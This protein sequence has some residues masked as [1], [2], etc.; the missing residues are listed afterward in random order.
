MSLHDPRRRPEDDEP[1]PPPQ[2]DFY[3]PAM[4]PLGL[5]HALEHWWWAYRRRRRFLRHI[6]PLLAQDDAQLAS[7]GHRR[8]DLQWALRLPLKVDA[9]RALEERRTSRRRPAT[10][11]AP[12]TCA[13][14]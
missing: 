2:P 14:S 9:Q 1:K 12:R 3:M 11:A 6:Q 4:P 10:S 8:A 7:R 5:I 13:L